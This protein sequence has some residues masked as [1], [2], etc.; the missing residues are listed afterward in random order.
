MLVRTAAECFRSLPLAQRRCSVCVADPLGCATDEVA[1]LAR[2][3]RSVCVATRKTALYARAAQQICRDC[4]AAIKVL[5]AGAPGKFD[6]LLAA[7]EQQL[8]PYTFRHAAV[9][10]K[11]SAS[12]DVTVLQRSAAAYAW[13]DPS[14]YGVDETLF[15]CA[16]HESCGF[17]LRETP[18]FAQ[19][20]E[21]FFTKICQICSI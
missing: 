8:A 2:Y 19:D 9:Y 1:L 3:V 16:L 15:L 7:E 12:S 17:R 10:R 11:S 21:K 4:G 6:I 20:A 14:P 13:F 18:V 5:P